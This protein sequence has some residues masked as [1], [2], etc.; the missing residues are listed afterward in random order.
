MFSNT[1]PPF[2]FFFVVA[3]KTHTTHAT[4]H[5]VLLVAFRTR[6]TF[7]PFSSPASGQ[8]PPTIFIHHTHLTHVWPCSPPF[9]TNST[10]QAAICNRLRRFNSRCCLTCS[11]R[12]ANSNSTRCNSIFSNN[13]NSKCKCN[14]NF[15]NTMYNNNNNNN[16]ITWR[17]P[18][19]SPVLP[20]TPRVFP[21]WKRKMK[22]RV[23]SRACSRPQ[24][25]QQQRCRQRQQ[26]Q[27]CPLVPQHISFFMRRRR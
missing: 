23:I 17:R 4:Q 18:R 7:L 15:N 5:R 14:S 27:R 1:T 20:T 26:H 10:F 11:L 22:I 24:R 25:Q 8:I 19:L 13:S 12:N 3:G 2:F 9:S 21:A 16:R 6:D